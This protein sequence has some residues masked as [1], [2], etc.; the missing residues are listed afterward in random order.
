MIVLLAF[1]VFALGFALDYADTRHKIAVEERNG[2][3]AGLWSVAMY[4]LGVFGTWAVLDVE[5]WLVV[6]TALGLYVGSR[7]AMPR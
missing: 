3:A 7:V 5:P 4:A 1:A 2:H 6:P